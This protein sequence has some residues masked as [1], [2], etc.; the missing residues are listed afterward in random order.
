M[1]V[2]GGGGEGGERGE[3]KFEGGGGGGLYSSA[4]GISS[5]FE[6][7]TCL[8]AA[9][10][11]CNVRCT[12]QNRHSQHVTHHVLC[13]QCSQSQF[14]ALLSFILLFSL[15]SCSAYCTHHRSGV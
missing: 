6:P 13:V 9:Q 8:V 1:W 10:C 14:H 5:A 2:G 7:L 12:L 3:G 11:M 4:Y 15:V